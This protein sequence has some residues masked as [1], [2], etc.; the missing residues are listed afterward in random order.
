MSA[1][2]ARIAAAHDVGASVLEAL[3]TALGDVGEAP[4]FVAVPCALAPVERAI[5]AVEED[6]IALVTPDGDAIVGI[7]SIEH[8]VLGVSA[9]VRDV[10]DFVTRLFAATEA[11]RSA[12]RPTVL[13]GLAFDA[14]WTADDAFESFGRGVLVAPRVAYVIRQGRAYVTA[15]TRGFELEATLE[16]AAK[17]VAHLGRPIRGG[18]P[19][20]RSIVEGDRERY[21]QSVADARQSIADGRL[22]K[23]VLARRLVV[24]L[25][26]PVDAAALVASL[27]ARSPGTYRFLLR[28]GE[29][30]FVGATPE[31]LVT[32]RDR[33]LATEAL[34]GTGKHGEGRA[35]VASVKDR[36]EQRWV[37]DA[38]RSALEPLCE[39]GLR[40]DTEPRPRELRD[41]VHLCTAIE[42]RMRSAVDVFDVIAALHP[43][44]A[45]GGVPREAAVDY[46]ASIEP[47][48]RGLYAAP[49]GSVDSAGDA[50][51]VVAL[52]SGVFAG[53][54]GLLHAGAGIVAD[55][56]PEHELEE[57]DLK[58]RSLLGALDDPTP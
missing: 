8:V 45:V 48:D 16:S 3:R 53:T 12:L 10:R 18:L 23:V 57:T 13:F 35:L 52:R 38:I 51:V 5:A 44:P 17:L 28:R 54:R 20:V 15:W 40:V 50:D 24:E 4:R 30:T 32:C 46:I 39:P 47:F 34:A 1:N 14:Q 19:G 25:G 49:F 42:G 2:A 6:G 33:N 55:S 26:C 22:D 7:G 36:A 27:G 21:A 58:L 41:V 9:T 11:E 37:V 56:V 29:A 31:R 43:T